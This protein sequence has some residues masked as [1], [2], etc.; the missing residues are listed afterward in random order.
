[1][2]KKNKQ[3]SIDRKKKYDI[4]Y[5]KRPEVIERRRK[6]Q[7]EFY[8]RNKD[9]INDWMKKYNSDPERK[10]KKKIYDKKYLQKPEVKKRRKEY[11]SREDIKEKHRKYMREYYKD[12]ENYKKKREYEK[13]PEVAKRINELRRKAYFKNK[14]KVTTQKNKTKSKHLNS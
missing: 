10:E 7:R 13:R 2:K 12:P 1:M 5:G 9:R 6:S 14:Q 4:E 8:Q 3:S 11:F